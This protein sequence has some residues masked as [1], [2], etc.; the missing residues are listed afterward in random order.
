MSTSSV[1]PLQK[2]TVFIIGAGASQEVNLP[3]GTGLKTMI[4]EAL[5]IR[6]ETYRL[7]SGNDYV[8]EVLK[9]I[10]RETAHASGEDQ[11]LNSLVRSALH[12]RDAMP[13]S[14]S[15]DHFID[16]HSGDKQIELCG[17]LAIVST[18]LE[19]EAASHM[20]IDHRE[21]K[22][23]MDFHSIENTWFHGF[24]QLLFES[25]KSSDLEERLS[26][27]ALV[28]FNYDRCIEHYLYYAIQ[29][30][31]RISAQD[32]EQ[33]LQRLEIYH[34]YGFVGPLPW[35][36]PDS[37]IGFGASTSSGKLRELAA[38][39]KTF[40]E[41]TDKTSSEVNCIRAIMKTAHKLVFL[42]FAFHPMNIELLFPKAPLAIPPSGRRVFATALDIS[43]SDMDVI[44]ND[45]ANRGVIS[46]G[47]IQIRND[48][49]CVR[50]FQEYRRSI[51]FA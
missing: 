43:H 36:S 9:A 49:K 24:E 32:T 4:A 41:G 13:Q 18:I 30:Y 25:C 14:I 19:A 47:D 11:L 38:Q 29:N 2:K 44:T 39:I 7:V 34:P 22:P 28:I 26:S 20:F 46:G 37:G 5:N 27:I 51:A 1:T 10:A 15:I 16:S 31:Y 3:I 23:S 45:L 48:L 12:I 21:S 40:T 35:F 50:L 6:F 8:F 42:G 33:I 17:K